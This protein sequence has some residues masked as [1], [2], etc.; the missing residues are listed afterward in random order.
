MGNLMLGTAQLGQ[1]Y[2]IA[3][4]VGQ[5]DMVGAHAIIAAAWG[6]GVRAFDTA[7]DYGD[8]EERMGA[9]FRTLDIADAARVT[10]KL[11]AEGDGADAAAIVQSVGASRE[12]LGVARLDGLLVRRTL[13]ARWGTVRPALVQMIGGGVVEHIGISVYTPEEALAALALTDVTFVQVPTSIVD[14]RFLTAE[15]FDRAAALGKRIV[16][17][18]VLLQGLLT[19]APDD[20]PPI[21]G[22]REALAGI[23]RVCDDRAVSPIALALAYVRE[24]CPA[25]DVLVGA[26]TALQVAELAAA[27]NAPCGACAA[28]L[29]QYVPPGTS[30][31]VD[32][33]RWHAA[34][35]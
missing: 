27:W 15:I 34:V 1:R 7:P 32:P 17:R 2:G 8:A 4:R 24:R 35:G 25:A 31:L 26:E 30:G 11:G 22:A 10:T 9:A 21:P 29:E 19:M 6:A 28:I 16:V 14:R 33:T 23:R 20:A 13:L 12:R 3:N 5:P 18:S